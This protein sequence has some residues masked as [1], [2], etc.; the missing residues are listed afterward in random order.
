MGSLQWMREKSIPTTIS[1][2]QKTFF[3]IQSRLINGIELHLRPILSSENEWQWIALNEWGTNPFHSKFLVLIH[4]H[5]VNRLELHLRSILSSEN[6]W[7]WT[8]FNEWGTNPCQQQAL[9]P[10]HSHLINGLELYLHTISSTIWGGNGKPRTNEGPIHSKNN[11]LSW[12]K[13]ISSTG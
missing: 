11:C 12:F 5:L 7:Q 2:P 6:E 13:A 10:I 8:A 9:V 4:S 3:R 1:C